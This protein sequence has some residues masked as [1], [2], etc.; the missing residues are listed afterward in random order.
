MTGLQLGWML[1]GTVLVETVFSWPGLGQYA[2]FSIAAFDF[3]AVIAVTILLSACFAVIN[4]I[5]D[6]IYLLLDP[7]ITI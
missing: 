1:G 6:F 4:L 5:T 3:R 7:R 2:F